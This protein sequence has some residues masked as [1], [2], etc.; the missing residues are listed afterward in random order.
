VVVQLSEPGSGLG[1]ELVSQDATGLLVGGQGAG[2]VPGPVAGE[3][4]LVP[5]FLPQRMPGGGHCMLAALTPA[6]LGDVTECQ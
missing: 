4:E 5:Q 3:H 2:P 1:S 6:T